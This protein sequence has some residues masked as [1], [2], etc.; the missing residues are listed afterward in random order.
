MI[1]LPAQPKILKCHCS[2]LEGFLER[3]VS[4]ERRRK[5]NRRMLRR[6]RRRV[7]RECKR[8]SSISGRV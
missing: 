4:E 8:D 5:W 6:E 3:G 1:P 2:G 7:G